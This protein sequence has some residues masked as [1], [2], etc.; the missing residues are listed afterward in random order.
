MALGFVVEPRIMKLAERLSRSYVRKSVADPVLREKLIPRYTMGCKRVLPTNDYL[1]TLQ[2]PNVELVTAPIAEIRA[3]SIATKDGVD[4]AVDV[5]VLATGFEAAEQVAPFEVRGRDGRELNEVWTDGA[6]AYLG[7]SVAGFPNL[8]M[9]VGPNTGLGHTSMI[10]MIESQV[11]YVLDAVKRMRSRG[12][13][14]VEVR[15]DAQAAYNALLQ[16]RLANTVWASGCMSW[17]LTRTGKNTTLWPGFTFEFRMRTRRFDA[18]AYD[19]RALSSTEAPTRRRSPP[20]HAPSPSPAAP[21]RPASP[22]SPR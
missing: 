11:A 15:P 16:R 3:H 9:L 19:E 22:A 2:R 4:R 8:F 1:P 21:L 6:E 5:V 12:L 17:Y 18:S 7:T 13:E 14:S 20:R 10:I